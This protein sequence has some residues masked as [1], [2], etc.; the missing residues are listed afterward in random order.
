MAGWAS[1]N[2][3]QELPPDW[4]TRRT[5]AL[6]RDNYQCQWRMHVGGICGIPA[7]DVDH[8][9]RGNDHRLANLQSLCRTHH[10]RKTAYEGREAHAPKPSRLRPR[11][12]HPGDVT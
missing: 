4:P 8:K 9:R 7:T 3:R 5:R 10:A 1:S 2:R 6:H 12:K 11:E